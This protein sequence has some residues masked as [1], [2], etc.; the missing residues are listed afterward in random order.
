[1]LNRLIGLRFTVDAHWARQSLRM[2][3]EKPRL[4]ILMMHV[5]FK[6]QAEKDRELIFPHEGITIL[7]LRELF[8]YFLHHNY[9]FI[10]PDDLSSGTCSAP[11]QVLLSFDDGYYNNHRV[12]PLLREYEVPAVFAIATDYVLHPRKFWWDVHYSESQKR[13]KDLKTLYQE[14]HELKS[15]R[16]DEVEEK[17]KEA[18][19]SQAFIP[20]GEIDRPFS[21]AELTDF[22]S[23]KWVY[24][25]NHSRHHAILTHYSEAEIRQEIADAQEDLKKISGKNPQWIAYPN[26]NC[27]EKVIKIATDV[28]LK[29]GVTTEWGREVPHPQSLMQLKRQQVFGSRSVVDQASILRANLTLQGLYK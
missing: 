8:E 7:Q 9:T 14:Q 20:Q 22:A 15:L 13:G 25:G 1:M 24:L 11:Y 26:G 5:L 29:V 18:Y 4:I 12:L 16:Y 17:L 10:S 19:G 27:S 28:G 23:E 3:K 2:F 6:D 21:V